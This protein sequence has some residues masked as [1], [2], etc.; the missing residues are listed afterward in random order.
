MAAT[1]LGWY[2][3]LSQLY[4]AVAEPVM[5]LVRQAAQPPVA[6][7]LLGILAAVSPCQLTTNASAIAW[8]AREGADRRRALLAAAAF[9]LGKA[10]VYTLFGAAAV[11][12][13]RGLAAAA[14][15]VFVAARKAL[16]PLMVLIG[17]VF[18]GLLPWRPAFGGRLAARL[19]ARVPR[20]GVTGAFGLGAAFAFAFCP[21]LALLFF[22]FLIPLTL[23]TRGGVLLPGL[24]AVGTTLPLVLFTALLLVGRGLAD[25]YL[26]G[27][28]AIDRPVRIAAGVVFLLAGVN[29]TVLYWTLR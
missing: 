14:V 29:D 7:L 9:V 15:P 22:T 16:G 2:A 10:L 21:T 26:G 17:L 20:G 19:K 23:A 4:A 18:L 3:T 12:A 6:A 27:A 11:L 8:V 13:G 28:G 1:I 25:R 24:F 5:G